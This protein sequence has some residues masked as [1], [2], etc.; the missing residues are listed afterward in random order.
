MIFDMPDFRRYI[1]ILLLCLSILAP[2]AFSSGGRKSDIK[3]PPLSQAIK[4]DTATVLRVLDGDTFVLSDDRRVRL[5]GL[6]TPEKG[7]PFSETAK[8]FADSVLRGRAVRLETGKE[9][10]DK[11]G[12]I[13]AYVHINSILY[14]ELLLKRGLAR[15]YLFRK[16]DRYNSRLIAAQKEARK[17]R[18][19][20][21]SLP[22]PE[23]E[24]YYISPGGSFRFHRPLCPLIKNINIK[25]AKK[26]KSR[27]TALD[28]G[29]SPCRE[30]R[31]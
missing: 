23:P 29:L 18:V 31:P 17:N 25:K 3:E 8:A 15:V 22:A 1:A 30:C 5:L 7:E 28:L 9:A 12:R 10:I 27:D 2:E 26:H 24:S 11:Y 4:G 14:N 6:D 19:G 13:L 20:V 16:N 21:W